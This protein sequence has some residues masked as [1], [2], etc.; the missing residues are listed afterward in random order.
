MIIS[1]NLPNSLMQK[2]I[3]YLDNAASEP[4][5]PIAVA[6]MRETQA[7]LGKFG[8]NPSANHRVGR[9]AAAI[10]ETARAKV[11]N[12]LG[13]EPPEIIFTGGGTESVALALRG[14]ALGSAKKAEMQGIAGGE[15]WYSAAEHDAVRAAA[16]SVQSLPTRELTVNTDGLLDLEN[17]P[18]VDQYN[19]P[20]VVSLLKVGNE[21]GVVQPVEEAIK[22]IKIA[23][24]AQYQEFTQFHTDAVAAAGKIPLDFQRLKTIY[25]LDAMSVAA[26]KV[27]G[28][29]AIGAIVVRREAKLLSDR[30]GGGQER[31]L[32]GGTQDVVAATGFAAALEE[33][34]K[35]LEVEQCRLR[36]IKEYL[37]NSIRQA[38]LINTEFIQPVTQANTVPN[39]NQFVVANA[40]SEALLME[41]DAAG[42]CVSAGSACHAG[43]ARPSKI[44]LAQGFSE[45]QALGALRIS[46]GWATTKAD[47]EQIVLA[48][49]KA[50]EMAQRLHRRGQRISALGS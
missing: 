34:V 37:L 9:L 39:L 31:Q 2:R 41:L 5:R 14:L 47:I 30:A 49:P 45:E 20:T 13:A 36:G 18:S 24:P 6:Q 25:G 21:N 29:A 42:V 32:R 33:A 11:A 28:P 26:H 40:H 4:L 10:L 17:I 38:G 16:N 46:F 48:L 23:L 1:E 3:A 22:Q 7:R 15:I 44:L 43:V 50:L 12:A 35:D 8:A 19:W 27:G